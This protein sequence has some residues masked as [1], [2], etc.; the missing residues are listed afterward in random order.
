MVTL[1]SSHLLKVELKLLH[2][3]PCRGW[4]WGTHWPVVS[5]T[6]YLGPRGPLNR[7]TYMLLESLR[8][9][10]SLAHRAWQRSRDWAETAWASRS[11][12]RVVCW[13]VTCPSSCR[14]GS[15]LRAVQDSQRHLG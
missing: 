12:S 3:L 11:L 6:P 9:S 7:K 2:R 8:P 4:G 5:R 1:F 10:A 15:G 13:V 14:S